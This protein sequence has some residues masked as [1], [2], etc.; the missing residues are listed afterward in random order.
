MLHCSNTFRPAGGHLQACLARGFR[1]LY[2][3]LLPTG[4]RGYRGYF[5]C[6]NYSACGTLFIFCRSLGR[7]IGD[8]LGRLGV[9]RIRCQM[10]PPCCGRGVDGTVGVDCWILVCGWSRCVCILALCIRH[11]RFV[12][13]MKCVHVFVL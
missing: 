5:N 3:T 7:L 4:S 13:V 8:V 1:K 10:F 11:I 6:Y 2:T 9:L 12:G